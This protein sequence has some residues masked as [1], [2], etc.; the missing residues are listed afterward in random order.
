[1]K[2]R[3][4]NQVKYMY[5]TTGTPNQSLWTSEKNYQVQ[6]EIKCKVIIGKNNCVFM[7]QRPVKEWFM[8]VLVPI[9]LQA[10]VSLMIRGISDRYSDSY[11]CRK[12][13]RNHP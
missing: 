7:G 9:N 3:H 10:R 1:M 5:V 8:N 6:S 13:Q 4:T 12:V 2:T 11:Q